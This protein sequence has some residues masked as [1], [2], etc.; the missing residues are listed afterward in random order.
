MIDNKPNNSYIY[1]LNQKFFNYPSFL[2]NPTKVN[3]AFYLHKAGL[4]HKSRM[5]TVQK[6]FSTQNKIVCNH[7]K[8]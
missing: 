1:F 6:Y 7:K 3:Y 2:I 8:N 5:T 4:Y